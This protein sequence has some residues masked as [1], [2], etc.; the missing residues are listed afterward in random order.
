MKFFLKIQG[1]FT[2]TRPSQLSRFFFCENRLNLPFFHCYFCFKMISR[3]P[4]AL[5]H[6]HDQEIQI[7]EK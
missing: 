1:F 3:N 6:V 7:R 4:L 5:Q 2:M